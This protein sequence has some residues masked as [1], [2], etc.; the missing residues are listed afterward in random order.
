MGQRDDEHNVA[1]IKLEDG[2]LIVLRN[3]HKGGFWVGRASEDKQLR[4]VGDRKLPR[5]TAVWKILQMIHRGLEG[6]KGDLR[7]DDT[8]IKFHVQRG[9]EVLIKDVSAMTD[10]ES[11]F[12]GG[13][14]TLYKAENVMERMG[15]RGGLQRGDILVKALNHKPGHVTMSLF[16]GAP[17][18]ATY[19][20]RIPILKDSFRSTVVGQIGT[21]VDPAFLPTFDHVDNKRT[22]QVSGVRGRIV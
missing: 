4:R 8:A 13:W 10:P 3:D 21:P 18:G 14:D 22:R 1:E 16:T 17:K 12:S 9:N 15:I 6:E 20:E 19:S 5:E 11:K 2:T 7:R